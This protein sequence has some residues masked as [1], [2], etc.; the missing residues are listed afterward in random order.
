MKNM[1]T[2]ET[3][4]SIIQTLNP[5][6][7]QNYYSLDDVG[8]SHLFSDTFKNYARFCPTANRYY[9]YNGTVWKL[10]ERDTETAEL[11]KTFVKAFFC[12]SQ[13]QSSEYSRSVSKLNSFSRR[14][15]ILQDARGENQITMSEFD[16]H[17]ELLNCRNV[18]LNLETL[19][20]QN[21]DPN[22]L[23]TKCANVVY[24]PDARSPDWEQ[25]MEQVMEG[26]REK[27]RYLQKLSGYCLT[28]DTSEEE[29]FILYGSTTRNGKSTFLETLA[30][31]MG[32]SDSGYACA[33]SPDTIALK[34]RDSSA[35]SSDIARLRGC[36]FL[37][38]SEPPRSMIFNV[39]L[40][41]SMLGRDTLTARNL[42]EREFQFIPQFKIVMNTNH[43]PAVNDQTLFSS[44]RVKVIT[45]DRHFSDEE[46]DKNLRSRLERPESLSGILNWCLE[47]LR[48]YRKE[49]LQEPDSVRNATQEYRKESDKMVLFFDDCLE[50]KSGTNLS[51]K[52]VYGRYTE[53]CQKNGYRAEKKGNFFQELRRRGLLSD[54]G[55]VSGHTERNVL[56]NYDFALEPVDDTENPFYS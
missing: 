14:K 18:V 35:P 21:H 55:T 49:G 41:K 38:C 20:A 11:C 9:T 43:L 26:D 7:D 25:F 2:L 52:S 19:E 32:D 16:S 13:D 34:T 24:D 56:C 54:S 42:N 23:F 33:M 51:G 6:A 40:L 50:E 48:M 12:Y 45:F 1:P 44:G 29:M 10:D 30:Y 31:M 4:L 46:Q 28:A 36:H 39:A 37:R 15:N 8:F 17:P 47:G 53:W 27:I 22:L 3:I 5:Y